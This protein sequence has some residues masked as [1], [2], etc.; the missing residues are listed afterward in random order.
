MKIEVGQIF[1]SRHKGSDWNVW[2]EIMSID[3]DIVVM[4][5]YG[6]ETTPVDVKWYKKEIRSLIRQKVLIPA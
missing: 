2:H 4:S 6:K 1:Y 3:G 5:N